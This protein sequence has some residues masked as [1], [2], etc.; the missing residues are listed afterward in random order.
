M[1]A[2]LN[3]APDLTSALFAWDTAA[4]LP[5]DLLTKVDLASMAHGLENR[6]PFLDHRLFERV[7]ALPPSRRAHPLRT[8]PILRRLARGRVPDADPPRA[9]AG[10]PASARAVAPRTASRAGSTRCS[11]IPQA[12]G[13]LYRPGAL[14]AELDRFRA[15]AG[16][17]HAP[18]RLWGLATLELWAREFHVEIP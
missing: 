5:D 3:G 10:L 15:G 14:R 1:T 18:Y 8:K 16:D 9:E 7:A 17:P 4:Y 12:T 13:R 6:S 2:G 11:S